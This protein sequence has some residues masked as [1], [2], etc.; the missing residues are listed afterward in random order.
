MN[1]EEMTLDR[2]TLQKLVEENVRYR[3]ALISI[4]NTDATTTDNCRKPIDQL[5]SEVMTIAINAL[6]EK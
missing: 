5:H 6:T 4:S 3:A 1:P 2:V